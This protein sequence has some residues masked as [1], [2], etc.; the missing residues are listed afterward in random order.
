LLLAVAVA[1][2]ITVVV[3]VVGAEYF[4]ILLMR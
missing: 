4:N 1:E 2:D 3:E